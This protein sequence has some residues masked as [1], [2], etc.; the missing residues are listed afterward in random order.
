MAT[1]KKLK[2]TLCFDNYVGDLDC[3]DCCNFIKDDNRFVICKIPRKVEPCIDKPIEDS[4]A[5]LSTK[6]TVKKCKKRF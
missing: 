1:Q 3:R 6:F 2:G 5:E 4:I